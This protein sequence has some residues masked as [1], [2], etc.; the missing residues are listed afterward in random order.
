M[1]LI[2]NTAGDAGMAVLNP[3]S[4][5]T[6]LFTTPNTANAIFIAY[7][8]VQPGVYNNLQEPTEERKPI[9]Y[10]LGPDTTIRWNNDDQNNNLRVQWSWAQME[11]Q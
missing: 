1:A 4:Y 2:T 8:T 7:I 11:I 10:I 6:I 9:K 5:G 3:L